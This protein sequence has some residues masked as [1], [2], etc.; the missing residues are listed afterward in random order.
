MQVI[1][2]RGG[3]S[4]VM[5]DGDIAGRDQLIR[6]RTALGHQIMMSDDGQTLMI[7]HSNGQ[8]YIE[9]GKEGTIDMYSTNSVNI[10]TQGDLNLHADNNVNIHATNSMNIKAKNINVESEENTNHRIGKDYLVSTL[11][12]YNHKV[13]TTMTMQCAD[14]GGFVSGGTFFVKGS[15][16]NL[17][18]GSPGETPGDVPAIP[19]I[20][21]TDTL[22]DATKGFI[23]APGKLKSI[24]SRVP[25]HAPWVNACQG[26]N[27][28]SSEIGRAHV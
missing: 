1:A 10:R 3:H 9:L 27:V 23:A 19:I 6:I 14:E 7:L 8:S 16:V 24:T 4:I 26:V 18:S 22:H 2:R 28:K 12:K 15:K 20:A 17:N 21:H 13:G 5:D 25:A 11:G